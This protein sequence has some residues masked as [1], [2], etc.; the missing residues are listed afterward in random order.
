[1]IEKRNFKKSIAI[2]ICLLLVYPLAGL[3]LRPINNL[4]LRLAIRCFIALVITGFCFYFMHGSK[5][6]SNELNLRHIKIYNT[7]FII[8]VAI[9]YL[10]FRLPIW[11]ELFTTQ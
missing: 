1:M 4:T 5:L 10:F 8:I 11:I 6:Y 2:W 3:V 9:F 7:I